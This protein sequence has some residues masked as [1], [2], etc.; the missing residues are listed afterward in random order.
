MDYY[1]IIINKYTKYI[2]DNNI[3]K[4]ENIENIIN[5]DETY[6]KL[7]IMEQDTLVSDLS[8]KL[9]I[10]KNKFGA[11]NY[12]N[13]EKNKSFAN[14]NNYK[15][16]SGQNTYDIVISDITEEEYQRRTKIFEKLRDIVLPEQRSKEWFDMRNNKITASDCGAVLGE[17]KYEPIYNFIH[18]KVFGSTFETNNSCYHGKKFENVV[19]LMYEYN[20]NVTVD[21][22]GLLGHEQYNF[23]GA[24]PDG[25]C[26]P[27]K[28]DGVTPTP[29]VGRMLEIKCPLFRK[30]KYEG[31]VKGEICPIYYWCQ[32][33][34][35]LECCDLDECDF[36][37]CHIEEYNTREDFI[38]D[39]SNDKNFISKKSGLEKGALIELIPLKIT[40]DDIKDGKLSDNIIYDKTSFIY[41]PKV[42]M[43]NIELDNWLLNEVD[44]ISKRRDVKLNRIIYWRI[45]EKNC[46]LI[47]RDKEWF[48]EALPKLQHIWNYVVILRSDNEMAQK[49]KD[50]I[51]NLPK[52]IN[53]KIINQ[54]D[55]FINEKK[56]V[57]SINISKEDKEVKEEK[58]KRKYTKK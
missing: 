55:F 29:L 25:I 23:L 28:R 7:D 18:K 46:T 47:P 15:T 50:F 2:T 3:D 43:S 16:I 39:S 14:K 1:N 49:W 33:Q 6:S 56:N 9:I 21:E 13:Y 52:K 24:S 27:V 26:R 38:E 35:Q 30:I 8:S 48:K 17:N 57:N 51:D 22:F 19:T 11:S 37:Q 41:Q 10:K 53:D 4:Y 34:Q 42:D 44:K 54:L 12:L 40:E 32:V 36:V 31:E 20:Y 58:N 5:N 45:L